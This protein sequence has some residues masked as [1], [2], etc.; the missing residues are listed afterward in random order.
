M[1]HSS[2]MINSTVRVYLGFVSQAHVCTLTLKNK[3][4]H[5]L[6][7]RIYSGLWGHSSRCSPHYHIYGHSPT[8]FWIAQS[9][10]RAWIIQN[11]IC[12]S[13]SKI[14]L[15]I[16][17]RLRKIR[18]L[19]KMTENPEATLK[20]QE[21]TQEHFCY[22]VHLILCS[23]NKDMPNRSDEGTNENFHLPDPW[24]LHLCNEDLN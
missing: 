17:V 3:D 14:Y 8:V 1:L 18:E 10:L 6:L 13:Q 20:C 5:D 9:P 7:M 15:W 4:K 22:W 11:I 12:C 19:F 21:Q 2:L 24:G 23:I 16:K